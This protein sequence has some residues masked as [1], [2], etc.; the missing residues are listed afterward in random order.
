MRPGDV[1]DWCYCARR[2][3]NKCTYAGDLRPPIFGEGAIVVEHACR[4]F[5]V[6]GHEESIVANIPPV[7]GSTYLLR[8]T[9]RLASRIERKPSCTVTM[10]AIVPPLDRLSKLDYSTTRKTPAPRSVALER[11]RRCLSRNMPFGV[12]AIF[13]TEQSSFESRPRGGAIT[14]MITVVELGKR[15]YH[16]DV[17]CL[18]GSRLLPCLMPS[19]N[20]CDA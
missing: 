8:S 12:D 3:N 4:S 16:F 6:C 20:T 7:P 9:A 18:L 15:C 10:K 2:Q 5:V 13:F 14:R 11:S 17:R 1:I 19:M